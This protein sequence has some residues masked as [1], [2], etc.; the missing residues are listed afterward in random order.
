MTRRKRRTFKWILVALHLCSMER[1][2]AV[3]TFFLQ[4]LNFL[5]FY[6][7][8]AGDLETNRSIGSSA[9]LDTI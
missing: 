8:L 3:E 9:S 7:Y 4:A 2:L 1:P 5:H 6:L